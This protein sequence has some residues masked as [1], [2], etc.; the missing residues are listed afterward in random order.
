MTVRFTANPAPAAPTL[1]LDALLLPQLKPGGHTDGTPGPAVLR[2]LCRALALGVSVTHTRRWLIL[3]G[4]VE[5]QS[6]ATNDARFFPLVSRARAHVALHSSP[7]GAAAARTTVARRLVARLTTPIAPGTISARREL[8]ARLA[9]AV[10][11]VHQL[12]LGFEKVLVSAGWLAARLGMTVNGAQKVLNTLEKDL[13]WIARHGRRVDGIRWKLTRLGGEE[14]RE[15]AWLH[16][17]T[18]DALAALTPHD[19]PLAS[20]IS[21]A[22]H[23]AW[24]YSWAEDEKPARILGVRH[25]VALVQAHAGL[26]VEDGLGL[27][28]SAIRRLR[29]ELSVRLPGALGAG[30]DLLLHLDALA[31]VTGATA[32]RAERDAKT[33]AISAATKARFA[34]F[35]QRQAAELEVKRN[36]GKALR[37]AQSDEVLGLIPAGVPGLQAWASSAAAY[38]IAGPG[39]ER[40]TPEQNGLARG[41][42]VEH[43]RRRGHDQAKADQVAK[44]VFRDSRGRAAA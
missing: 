34:E 5:M 16:A 13:H 30:S 23:E 39:A 9:L 42:L 43:I 40:I 10:I 8:S 26:P 18:V 14:E 17:P 27:A 29:R 28:A 33:A 37:Y 36:V 22:A 6:L 4:S 11:G 7:A 20:I 15:R 2:V 24:S 3:H 1:D 32:L 12:E 41:Y 44:F 25:W 35:Q 38:F 19:D 21:T 31:E